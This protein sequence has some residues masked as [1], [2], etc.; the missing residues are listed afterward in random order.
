MARVRLDDDGAAGRQ[1]RCAIP[2]CDGKGEGE[3]AGG[4]NRHRPKREL[5]L[6]DGGLAVALTIDNGAQVGAVA[7]QRRE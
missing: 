5:H 7:Q 1:G 4:E 2:A 6:L 3:V